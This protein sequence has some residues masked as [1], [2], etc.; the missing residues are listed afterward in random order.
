LALSYCG[1]WEESALAAE[2]ALQLSPRDPFSATYYGI[3]GYAQF[4]GR[5]YIEAM[6][7]ARQGSASAPIS[8]AH[9][10]F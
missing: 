7:L 1:R 10:V 4:V 3:A 2:R 6:R 9:T 8:S 5:N